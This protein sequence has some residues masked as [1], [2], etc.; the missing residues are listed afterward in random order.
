VTG[1]DQHNAV[2]ARANSVSA[3]VGSDVRAAVVGALMPFGAG[4]LIL[5]GYV[6]LGAFGVI[7]AIAGSIGWAVWWRRRHG[8]FFPRDVET[9][10]FVGTI[11][12]A[13]IAFIIALAQ[14]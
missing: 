14:I 5:V 12:I 10:P 1:H 6:W 2:S 3:G 8:A 13:A 4:M 11:A 9:G 7:L